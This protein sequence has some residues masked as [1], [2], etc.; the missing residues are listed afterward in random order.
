MAVKAVDRKSVQQMSP[1]IRYNRSVFD[2]CI[3]ATLS[4]EPS[5]H[6]LDCR[7]VGPF[8]WIFLLLFCYSLLN[9]ANPIRNISN[10]TRLNA[11]C[12]QD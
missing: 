8:P 7:G 3:S 2:I 6:L 5:S 10:E 1:V 4:I 11:V 12:I 9:R